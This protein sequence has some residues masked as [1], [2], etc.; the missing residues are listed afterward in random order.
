MNDD[1][2]IL[3]IGKFD[4][5]IYKEWNPGQ[6]TIV[7]KLSRERALSLANTIIEKIK[8]DKIGV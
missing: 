7:I 6:R 2:F 3:A 8:N 1:K 5:I 4:V